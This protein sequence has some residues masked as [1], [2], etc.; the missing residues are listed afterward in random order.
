ML[1]EFKLEILL[2]LVTLHNAWKNNVYSVLIKNQIYAQR[3]E[4]HKEKDL[5]QMVQADSQIK[6]ESQFII[7]WDAQL[8]VNI[9]LLHKYQQPK[10]TPRLT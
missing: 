9:Q 4:G 8:L 2:F 3:L 6:K 1:P 5:C 7:L 10:L